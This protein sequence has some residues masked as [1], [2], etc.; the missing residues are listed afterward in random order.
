MGRKTKCFHCGDGDLSVGVENT[1]E[2]EVV[3]YC[4]QCA[5]SFRFD[6]EDKP[7]KPSRNERRPETVVEKRI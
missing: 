2:N 5:N 7:V 3:F 6:L 1:E 4:G